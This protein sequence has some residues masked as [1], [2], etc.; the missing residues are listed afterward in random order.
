MVMKTKKNFIIFIC[1]AVFLI[2]LL[3]AC[4]I[5]PSERSDADVKK[6]RPVSEL[7]KKSQEAFADRNPTIVSHIGGLELTTRMA[8]PAEIPED[9]YKTWLIFPPGGAASLAVGLTAPPM[10]ASALVVG[11]VFLVP[12]GTYG[13]LYEKGI[14]DSINGALS[15][16]EFTRLIDTA[17][18]DRLNAAFAGGSMPDVKVELIIQ[19]FG[20]VE[21]ASLR[22]HC[23]VVSA[24]FVLSK[25]NTVLNQDH[26]RITED[27]RSEDAPPPQCASLEHFAKNEARLVK[28]TLAE[29]AGVLAVMAT[30]RIYRE[31]T[32]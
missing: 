24:D 22:H 30:D 8:T 14:W 5:V 6:D 16:A 31:G 4:S 17:M 13:Y 29:Y 10:F 7:M 23:F 15:N 1:S 21:Y 20:L 11:G 18:K 25:G 2:A 3:Q 28:D 9:N 19:A 27:N 32:K 12:A 26:L